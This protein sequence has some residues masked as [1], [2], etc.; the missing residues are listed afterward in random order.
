MSTG[1]KEKELA[2]RALHQ[3]LTQ[4]LYDLQE[5]PD[6]SIRW[7]PRVAGWS[8][9]SM[10]AQSSA[11]PA[12]PPKRTPPPWNK[13]FEEWR[14]S[15]TCSEKRKKDLGYAEKVYG[16]YLGEKAV[17]AITPADVEKLKTDLRQFFGWCVTHKTI[18]ENPATGIKPPKGESREGV[19]FIH[20]ETVKLLNACRD[21]YEAPH[22]SGKGKTTKKPP[23]WLFSFVFLGLRTGLRRSNLRSLK[24][25]QVDLEQRKLSFVAGEMKM[26]RRHE[27]PIHEE[28]L[29]FLKE[30]KDNLGPAPSDP[31]IGKGIKS[32]NAVFNA[33]CKR[34]GLEGRRIHDMRHTMETWLAQAGVERTLRDRILA[35]E[36]KAGD[37]AAKYTHWT[38]Q[39]VLAAVDRM[40]RLL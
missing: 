19:F 28:L 16:E 14:G 24:W 32:V 21:R 39:D 25:G 11:Q 3:L 1:E 20:E 36:N 4:P 18:Q 12:P 9:T 27:V 17:D 10:A 2:A 22:S 23:E 38:W 6:G 35:H 8:A 33:A 13:T 37:M 40:P 5:M 31:V 15:L 29:A 26:R 30:R 7:I 34:V